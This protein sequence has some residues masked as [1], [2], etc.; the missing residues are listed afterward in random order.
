MFD[1][2]K[3]INKMLKGSKKYNELERERRELV[4]KADSEKNKYG[5]VDEY[6][7]S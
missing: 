5:L 3:S 6:Q 4:R 1:I 7:K 2:D